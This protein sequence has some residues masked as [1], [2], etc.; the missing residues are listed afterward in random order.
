MVTREPSRRAVAD[1]ALS[2]QIA[3]IHTLSLT[4]YGSPRVHAE[5][6]LE[7][8]VRVGRKRVERLMRRAGLSGLHPPPAR[9]HHD[10]R[11]GRQDGP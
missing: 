9:A 4:T 8:D 10:P 11:A 3:E 7:H 1:A 2:V 6:A 5:L